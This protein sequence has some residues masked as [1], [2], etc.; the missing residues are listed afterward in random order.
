MSAQAELVALFKQVLELCKIQEH[1][2][3]AVLTQDGERQ[4]Y[5]HAYLAAAASLGAQA[6]QLN[7]ARPADG[8]GTLSKQ[9]ALTGNRAAIDTLKQADLLID[10]VGLLWSAEQKEIQEAGTR[11]LM[12]REP[13]EILRRMFP[14]PQRR[15]RVEAAEAMLA[16]AHELRVSSAAGTDV[17]YRLG[18][19]P[20]ITQYGYTDRP[21]RWDNLSAGGFLYT[22]AYD[23]GVDG[24]VVIDRGDIIFPFKRYVE[25]SITLRIAQGRIQRIE[26]DGVDAELLREYMD[27]YDDPRAYAISH[28]GWGL[29]ES[30]R[31][32]FMGT[33]PALA[34]VSNGPD[35][36]S[37][38]GNVLFSTGPNLELGGSNDTGCHLDIP[39]R[40]CSLYLDGQAIVEE[41]L[42]VPASLRP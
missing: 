3:L 31:W 32:D 24:T 41:G 2:S 35:G 36:R 13:V 1:E 10:L 16:Q 20:V 39:L 17:R 30:A 28:I 34:A 12:S 38:C 5:A 22:G 4:D 19:Y 26:G 27:R 40:R 29:D 42:L 37:Y 33:N 11:I 8:P 18:A 23:D 25:Q 6:Y 15:R 21:G 7:V 9:T 14:T